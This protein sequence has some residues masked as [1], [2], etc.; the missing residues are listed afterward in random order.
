M[1]PQAF[2]RQVRFPGGMIMHAE[3][4]EAYNELAPADKRLVFQPGHPQNG[5]TYLQHPLMQNLYFEVN[6]FHQSML[7]RKQ[8]EL[9]RILESLGAYR[10]SVEIRHEQEEVVNR[11][12]DSHWDASADVRYVTGAVSRNTSGELHA[13]ASSF[14]RAKKDWTFNPPPH[15]ALPE[16][17]V[18]YPSEETWQQ[19]AKSV[20]RGGLK[21]AVVDLEYKT[22][23]GITEKHLSDLSVAAK[24]VLPSFELNLKRS[25]SEDLH[26]LTTTQWHYEVEFED[27][28]GN[29][30]GGGGEA[31]KLAAASPASGGDAGKVEALFRKRAKRYA[32]SEGHV[33]AEQRADLEAFA[34]KYGID[35]FRMEEL[36]EEAFE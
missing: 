12:R 17:L 2:A 11:T 15:P 3:E 18:F 16:D 26:Q 29:R 14:Q 1:V 27:E 24:V 31:P 28:A 23:F 10:A 8:N 19:L 13:S 36:I 4:L 33:N 34:Q 32:Q 20:L 7:E 30:A 35:E 5:C 25:F 22:E 21:S 6:S 9:L